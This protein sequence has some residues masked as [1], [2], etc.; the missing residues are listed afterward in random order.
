[1]NKVCFSTDLLPLSVPS[2]ATG[3]QTELHQ[4]QSQIL[5]H[6]DRFLCMCVSDQSES[7]GTPTTT[8]TPLT[9]HTRGCHMLWFGHSRAY[10]PLQG[11]SENRPRARHIAERGSSY[12]PSS[13]THYLSAGAGLAQLLVLPPDWKK[14]NLRPLLFLLLVLHGLKKW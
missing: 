7:N 6:T 3:G 8:P 14:V 10:M 13:P 9:L 11:T 4:S 5:S 12:L 2:G 1:M